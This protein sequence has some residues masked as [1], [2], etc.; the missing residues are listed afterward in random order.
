MNLTL[1]TAPTVQPVSVPD[2]ARQLNISHSDD[3][4]LLEGLISS[5]T[6]YFDGSEGILGRALITQTWDLKID[7]PPAS[8]NDHINLPLPPLQ[9][10]TYIKYYDVDGVLQTWAS[11]NYT[12]DTGSKPGRVYPAYNKSWPETQ[13]IRNAMTIR[14]VCG[15]GAAG[16]SVPQDLKQMMLGLIAHWY[17]NREAV[18][19]NMNPAQTP[20]FVQSIIDR[21]KMRTV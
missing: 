9:S 4:L 10:I 11:S 17:E 6:S 15:Y 5:V 19:M 21:Y 18:S 13:D 8:D 2:A 12:V 14:M 20:F 1:I 16:S 3:D 7:C